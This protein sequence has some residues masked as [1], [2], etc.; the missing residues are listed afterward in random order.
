M[1]NVVNTP[2][3]SQKLRDAEDAKQ[4]V[5]AENLALKESQRGMNQPDP[6]KDARLK[7]AIEEAG[8]L[9]NALRRQ[10]REAEVRKGCHGD[11][12]YESDT[13]DVNT[14]CGDVHE[15]DDSNGDDGDHEGNFDSKND[16]DD[17]N[18]W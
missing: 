6:E 13:D 18:T 7:A 14:Y 17:V 11:V 16:N 5:E 4:F 8:K 3:S 1:L 15:D 12:D 10:Q 9:K 2:I